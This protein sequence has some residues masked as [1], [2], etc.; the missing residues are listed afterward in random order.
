[1]IFLKAK[2]PTRKI[3]RQIEISENER[4]DILIDDKYAFELKVPAK[5]NVLRDLG[6]QLEEY[7]QKYPQ[8][9]AIIFDDITKNLTNDINEYVDKY[10]RNYRIQSIV[11]R[12][13]KRESKSNNSPNDS[14]SS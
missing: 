8:T 5:R 13:E 7:S 14:Q 9:C 2:F 11:L 6:A 3:S 1:M 12:G 10:K 4:L